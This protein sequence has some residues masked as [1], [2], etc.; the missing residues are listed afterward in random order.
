MRIAL[1]TDTCFPTVNGV[2]R[3]LGLL[4]DHANARGH[5][6][7]LVS[8][9]LADAPHPGASVHETIPGVRLPFY[10]ELKAARPWLGARIRR[11]LRRFSPDVVHVA[12]EALVGAAGRRWALEHGVPLVTSYCTN[13]P[14]YLA[15]YRM[16]FGERACWS[17]LRRF[18]AAAAVT[19]CPSRATLRDLE[20]RG[21]HT[22][23]DLWTRGV[24]SELFRPDRRNEELR[25]TMAPD[26][27]IVLLY[28]GRIAP[29][30][31]IDLLIQAL[32]RIRSGT[33]RRVGLVL[34]GGGPARAR[35]EAAGHP[36]VH[37][38]GYRRGVD[39]AAHYASADAFVFASDTETFGQVVS[40]ALS[41]GLP[42]VAPDRGGVTDLVVAGET[43]LLF[44][45]GRAD[46][47]AARAISLVE[48]PALRRRMGREGRKRAEGRSWEAVFDRLFETYDEASSA[49]DASV[50]APPSFRATPAR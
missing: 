19:L 3:A 20:S 10:P 38:A 28:V 16:G 24:D 34:V 27:D 2:A 29:E 4:I 21:F 50:T 32:P 49:R 47:L 43:G 40:E 48:D 18:H 6:V 22:R 7:C 26:A 8:P 25:R 33:G 31:K 13:F 1:F 15:G 39:L 11:A 14:D 12:T 35:L 37:F 17:Y 41:S 46:Q 5:S 36:D 9:N 30:K 42:V 44:Q 45:P 23:L